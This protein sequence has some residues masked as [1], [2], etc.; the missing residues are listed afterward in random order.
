TMDEVR[1]SQNAGK[2]VVLEEGLA[3]TPIG[4]PP[5]DAQFLE[6]RLNQHRLIY[7][8]YGIPAHKVGDLGRS[9]NNNIE[10]QALEFVQDGGVPWLVNA[11]QEFSTQLI[12]E[13]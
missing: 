1:G 8:A 2:T 6:A 7:G 13:D 4:F 3:V 5:E 12:E 11:E 10:H 9:T